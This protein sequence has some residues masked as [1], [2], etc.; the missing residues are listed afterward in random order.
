MEKRICNRILRAVLPLG[1]LATSCATSVATP[2]GLAAPAITPA[3]ADDTPTIP[4]SV[5][6]TSAAIGCPAIDP[7]IRE[8]LHLIENQVSELR[9]LTR[10]SAVNEILLSREQLAE[11]VE[12]D[13]LADYTETEAALDAQLLSLLGLIEPGLSLRD[14]YRSLL[15]EQIAGFYD[16]EAEELVIVCDTGFGGLEQ[17]TYAHEY[18]HMLQDQVF[19]LEAGLEYS[20]EACEVGGERCFAL[21]A[22]IEGDASLLEEQWL[23][24]FG[25]E[26]V[27]PELL[28]YFDELD[29][30]VFDDAPE[31]IRDELTFPYLEG[32]S[33]ARALYLAGGWAA[34]DAAYSNPPLSSEQILHPERYP[35]DIPV[36]FEPPG[37]A[38]VLGPGWKELAAD[39]LGEWMTRMML[40][41]SL[42]P[43]SAVTAAE[44]WGGDFVLVLK[45]TDPERSVLVL[46]TQWDSIRDAREFAD[47][48]QVYG[49]NRFGETGGASPSELTW[50]FVGGISLF[51]RHGNQTLWLIAPD[52]DILAVLSNQLPLPIW[53]SP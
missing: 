31:Y 14:L 19:D 50:D 39:T 46:L 45:A 34:V 48:F 30:P 12:Q 35:R 26:Q 32:L 40:E 16:S 49:E 2:T 37:L 51:R 42:D 4:P 43:E 29:M 11:R 10:R 28:A 20:D 33:F 7:E 41:E 27:L 47:A 25:L 36:V 18:V 44:G 22:L 24:T 13:L 17:V 15:K 52:P 23:R 6:P 5:T 38:D 1:L 3:L 9:G 53:P 8:Q 21:Q